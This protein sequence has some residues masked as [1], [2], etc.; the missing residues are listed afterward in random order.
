MKTRIH[1]LYVIV[2]PDA[3]NGHSPAETARLALEGGASVIQWRD[4]RRDKGAQLPDASTIRDLCTERGAVFIVN[5]HADLAVAV[6]ADGVHLGQHDL[7][8][9]DVRPLVGADM[10]IGVSTNTPQEALEAEAAG[11]DYVA[12]GAI[13]PT[14]SKLETRP[15]TLTS[16]RQIKHAVSVPVVAIGGIRAENIAGVVLSGGDAAAVISAVCG[17]ADPRRAASVLASAFAP[18]VSAAVDK[19]RL[20]EI[21]NAYISTINNRERDAFAA[22]FAKDGSREDPSGTH[23]GRDEIGRSWDK[24]QLHDRPFQIRVHNIVVVRQEAALY[25]SIEHRHDDGGAALA[26][27]VE[28]IGVEDSG[29]IASARSYWSRDALPGSRSRAVA[30]ATIAALNA[31]DCRAYV[32]LWAEDGMWQAPGRHLPTIGAENIRAACDA[33]LGTQNDLSISIDAVCASGTEVALAW[34]STL[35][36]KRRQVT[37]SGVDI[38]EV[39]ADGRISALHSYWEPDQLRSVGS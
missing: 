23:V 18:A 19:E 1:G 34:T 35:S 21:V 29:E 25:W 8:I 16:L 31:K 27:G 12:V 15:S 6:G 22:L 32:E 37:V 13:F 24:M 5:D 11:A 36:G 30:E 14:H 33:M 9:S 4:K 38:I 28:I 10:L 2:D 3:C 20:R 26:H 7:N 17:A 39:D